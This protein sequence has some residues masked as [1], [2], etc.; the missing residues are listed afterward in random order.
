MHIAEASSVELADPSRAL[1]ENL[2]A[3]ALNLRVQPGGCVEPRPRV[4][5]PFPALAEASRGIGHSLF[6]IDSNG[7]VRRVSPIVQVGDRAIRRSRSRRR[8]P[9]STLPALNARI[10]DA[11]NCTIMI[12]WRGP[13]QNSDGQPT[14]TSYSFYDVFYSQQQIIE[15]QKPGIDPALFKDRIVIV[16]VHRRRA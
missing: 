5:P 13:A 10:D 6:T 16:G 3:P 8:L 11:G 1:K 14:F 2:D 15:G 7:A 9:A 4:T 12:P